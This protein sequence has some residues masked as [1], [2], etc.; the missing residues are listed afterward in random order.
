MGNIER[1]GYL[2]RCCWRREGCSH[3]AMMMM[4]RW[5]V[6]PGSTHAKDIERERERIHGT[7]ITICEKALALYVGGK[8]K[9]EIGRVYDVL[10][11]PG[12]LTSN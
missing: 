9:D 1:S 10:S 2:T 4:C 7:S 12:H 11:A 6:A 5:Q 8:G 3:S